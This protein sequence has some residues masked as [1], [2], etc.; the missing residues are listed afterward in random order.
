MKLH[1]H[2]RL[3]QLRKCDLMNLNHRGLFSCRECNKE[4]ELGKW[5]IS[6]KGFR[7]KIIRC[8]SCAKRINLYFG[9]LK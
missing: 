8:M 7:G 4:F 5:Y 1:N 6:T 2:S 3:Y 9:E